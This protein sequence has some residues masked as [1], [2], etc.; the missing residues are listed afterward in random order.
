MEN[1]LIKLNNESPTLDSREVAGM[2]NKEHDK[3]LRDIRNYISQMKQANE[4]SPSLES[5][6]NP[7]D[8]FIDSTYVNRQNKK[9]P[10]YEITKLGCEFVANK[11]TGVKGTAFT[12]IYIKRFNQMEQSFK[13]NQLALANKEI[14]ELKNV[15]SEFKRLTE[16]AKREYKPSHKR[17]LD[18]NKMI[19]S[20]TNNRDEA[21]VVKDWVFGI[22][23]INKWEESCI[24]D[25]KKIVETI[26][27]VARL[28]TIKKFE[29]L[30]CFKN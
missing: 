11:L 5:P 1:K 7:S 21:Q 3:L 9:Q 25:S 19:R 24:E 18:Y 23:G 8:Y 26:S 29:Q 27:T 22:L 13:N 2:V 12:A 10:C 4:E 20:L 16:D 28:L 17:K 30:S 6:I 14:K 15:V